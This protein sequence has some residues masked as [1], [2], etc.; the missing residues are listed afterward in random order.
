MTTPVSGL[1]PNEH[2]NGRDVK[3][4][5]KPISYDILP[6]EIWKWRHLE[7]T[8][9]Q[10]AEEYNYEEVRTS[11]LQP[12]KAIESA[13]ALS[14][15]HP[16]D[17]R[18]SG[19]YYALDEQ[20]GLRTENAI[21]VLHSALADQALGEVQKIYYQGAVFPRLSAHHGKP[22]RNQFGFE[23]LGTPS[24]IAEIELMRIGHRICRRLRIPNPSL[25]VSSHGCDECRPAYLEA[26]NRHRE[27]HRGEYCRNC[28]EATLFYPMQT[29]DCQRDV[30]R[31]LR[32]GAPKITDYLCPEC[33]KDLDYVL[34]VLANLSTEHNVNPYL[35]RPYGFYNRTVFNVVSELQGHREVIA[36]GGR[37]DRLSRIVTG[38]DIPAAGLSID[39]EDLIDW[40]ERFSLFVERDKPFTVYACSNLEA[41]DLVL[42]Q[43]TQE[44][45]DHNVHTI[46]ESSDAPIEEIIDRA[47]ARKCSL[48]ILLRD[49]VIRQGKVWFINLVKEYEDMVDLSDILHQV[50]RMRK[51][52]QVE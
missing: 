1:D 36:G 33:R 43:I 35:T 30:C 23:I 52:L 42:L 29:S 8:L 15:S 18:I 2:G 40:M 41:L 4:M 49:D 48:I 6:G 38:E 26:L 19:A 31:Q 3:P 13:F 44:L 47:T 45:H 25:E 28:P 32:E 9:H 46:Q 50:L 24:S 12:R 27:D 22:V 37:Y 16:E 21:A 51:S 17:P 5:E 14:V 11:I 34:K 39:L 10:L 7:K 20:Y